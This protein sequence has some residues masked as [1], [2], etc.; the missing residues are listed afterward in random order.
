MSQDAIGR[1]IDTRFATDDE[2]LVPDLADLD[3]RP[4]LEAVLM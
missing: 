2:D 1:A 4:A 3:L